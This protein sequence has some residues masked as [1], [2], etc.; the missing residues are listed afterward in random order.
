MDHQFQF[1][2]LHVVDWRSASVLSAACG[3]WTISLVLSAAFGWWTTS[4]STICCMWLMNDQLQYYLLHKVDWPSAP[5]L[6]AVVLLMDHQ[7]QYFLLQL[8]VVD[9][10]SAL[11]LSAAYGWWTINFSSICCMWLTG[12][13][14]QYYLLQVEDGP[15]APAISAACGWWAI[16]SSTT[17]CIWLM[18]H[19]L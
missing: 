5:E 2:L 19:Q 18:D 9:G 7:L 6:S 8:H 3:W 1:Y 12:H 16:S 4:F 17:Y 10:P 13:L 14:L 15:S 11:V